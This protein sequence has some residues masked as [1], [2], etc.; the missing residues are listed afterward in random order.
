MPEAEKRLHRFPYM[1]G[2]PFLAGYDGICD[3]KAVSSLADVTDWKRLIYL[4]P[5]RL[6]NIAVRQPFTWKYDVYCL[7][8]VLLEIALWED[9]TDGSGRVRKL[10]KES[11]DEM[12]PMVLMNQT[13]QVPRLLGNRFADAVV[14]CLRMLE[15]EEA[16]GKFK[17][18]DELD[19]Q[20]KI[21][22]NTPSVSA[23]ADVQQQ[24]VFSESEGIKAAKL[25]P[26]LVVPIA[27]L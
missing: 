23:V 4:A 18:E 14:A 26:F 15:N 13:K 17:D 2:R 12:K 27:S 1:I 8:A 11:S 7:G 3:E 22:S 24:I 25:P 16:S 19:S 20:Q 9:F 10:L 21:Y 5:D 6:G